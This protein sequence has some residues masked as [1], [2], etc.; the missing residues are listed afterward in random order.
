MEPQLIVET[1]NPK[2][3]FLV[4]TT[5]TQFIFHLVNDVFYVRKLASKDMRYCLVTQLNQKKK[6]EEKDLDIGAE[7]EY[8]HPRLGR[9]V[10]GGK[11]TS[12]TLR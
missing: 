10:N 4:G 11:V 8:M 6:Y 5:E 7:V 9:S 2:K 3:S 12:I 1:V